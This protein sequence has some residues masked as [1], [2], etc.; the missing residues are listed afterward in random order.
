MSFLKMVNVQSDDKA[1]KVFFHSCYVKIVLNGHVWAWVYQPAL[2]RSIF[3]NVGMVDGQSHID[4]DGDE[5]HKLS[6]DVTHP[7]DCLGCRE[8][9]K[10]VQFFEPPVRKEG[11]I[12]GRGTPS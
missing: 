12:P 8:F 7:G 5:M 9:V 4:E 2:I 1:V 6:A 11:D 3:Q 10:E